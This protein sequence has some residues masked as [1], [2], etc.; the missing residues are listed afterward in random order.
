MPPVLQ[1][2]THACFGL[3]YLGALTLTAAGVRWPRPGLRAA[4]LVLGA[5]GLVAHTA[6]LLVHH[7]TP[8][9]PAGALLGLAWVVAVFTLYGALHA[10]KQAW[11]VFAFPVVLG[12]VGLSLVFA[13]EPTAAPAW[14]VGEHFWGAA[15]G[16]LLLLAAVGL[17]VGFLASV[18]YLVQARRLRDK[19]S[20][21]RGM[22]LLSL[23][24]LEEMSRRAVA[25]AFPLLTGGLA[26]G[27]VLVPG[28][29][30]APSAAGWLSVKVLGTALLWVVCGVLFYLRYAAHVPG[31]RLARLTI[32]AFAL[33]VIVLASA[34]PFAAV[35][36]PP[37]AAEWSGP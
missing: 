32:V 8:A 36:A 37:P 4:G 26:L 27:A 12:L 19:R 16:L 3:G 28:A 2:V 21:G 23:E 20:L 5:A 11:P 10:S 13:T 18:M 14:V 30:P 1:N 33:T 24:R 6:F 25:V 22:R 34:H 15:H 17:T 29:T 31:R 7:P 35:P 9:T